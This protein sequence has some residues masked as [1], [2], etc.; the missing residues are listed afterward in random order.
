MRA[1]AI[2]F[3]RSKCGEFPKS[4]K[5]WRYIT[6]TSKS[7][8][9]QWWLLVYSISWLQV[10]TGAKP[11][12]SWKW[13]ILVKA[14]ALL[15]F[16]ALARDKRRVV[17]DCPDVY[18]CLTK[19]GPTSLWSLFASSL[20]LQAK[21]SRKRQKVFRSSWPALTST[22]S[23]CISR[24]CDLTKLWLSRLLRSQMCCSRGGPL[25]PATQLC[26]RPMSSETSSQLLI[27]GDLEMRLL[28][29]FASWGENQQGFLKDW[30]DI[31]LTWP[32]CPHS[33]SLVH[34]Y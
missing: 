6:C 4:L 31:F 10:Q 26:Y 33:H 18:F 13:L 23:S 17:E 14:C 22:D 19:A 1:S 11:K 28:G 7:H 24:L 3:C 9:W 12:A 27:I 15:L 25:V 16:V 5:W 30:V 32:H 20:N 8:T 21:V 2:D 29:R 34:I